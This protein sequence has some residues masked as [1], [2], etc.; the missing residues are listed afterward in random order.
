LQA[1]AFNCS[2]LDNIGNIS[3]LVG[4]IHRIRWRLTAAKLKLIVVPML[5]QAP[6][7][8][9]PHNSGQQFP[10]EQDEMKAKKPLT[11]RSISHLSFASPGKR[12]IVW[13]AIVP[14]LGIRVTDRG[15]KSFVLVVRYPG[16]PNPT[17]RSLGT[18]GAITLEAARA[19][20]R[21]W[22]ALIANG[23]DPHQHLAR[24]R[25]QTFQSISEQ[26]LLRKA[27]DQRSKPQVEAALTRLVYPSLGLR[28]IT[29]INRSDIVRLLDQIEDENGPV[30]ATQTLNIIGRVM[31]FHAS[32]TDDFKSPIVKGMGRGS[33]QARSRILGDDE[34]R[35]IWAAT[36]D[37][38]VFGRLLRFILLTATRRYEAGHMPWNEINDREWIIPAARYKTNI[39]HVIPLSPLALSV[40]PKRLSSQ[41]KGFVFSA[42]GRQAIGNYAK[43]KQSIDQ[44]S[45]VSG[46]VI[47]DLRRSARSLMSRAGVHPDHAERCLGHVIGGVR[48][49]YDRHEYLEEKR[50][51]FEALA[52]QVQRIVDPQPNVVGIGRR[53]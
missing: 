22:L 29:E 20:A 10:Q 26:Y 17:P 45:G 52:A 7:Q 19:K 51:A 31:N 11:D 13:D 43:H 12:R 34:L 33:A 3:S 27:K 49:V 15:V 2:H 42:N 40:L 37:Y 53:R 23:T 50:R 16:S 48:G 18:Y 38:P 35:A 6:G 24:K 4:A 39:D 28:P 25:E 47:H 36:D 14:G 44:I 9:F 41:G 21:D 8:Q 1:G 30:M 46:W 5:S 32:R